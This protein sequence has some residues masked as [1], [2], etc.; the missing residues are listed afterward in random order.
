MQLRMTMDRVVWQRD[1]KPKSAVG[2][3]NQE[4]SQAVEDEHEG[5]VELGAGARSGKF[6]PGKDSPEGSD[7][8]C[9]LSDGVGNGHAG[10]ARGGH[11]EDGADAPDD[12]AQQTERM[13]GGGSV[14]KAAEVHGIADQRALHEVDVPDKAGEQGAERQEDAHTIGSEGVAAGHG[15]GDKRSPQAHQDAGN[16]ADYNTFSRHRTTGSGQ[17]AIGLAVKDY[18]QQ[19]AGHTGSQEGGASLRLQG[20][21]QHHAHDQGD[22]DGNRESDRQSGHVNGSDQ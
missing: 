14:E 16:D 11:I 13:A 4:N 3:G 5:E 12:S 2:A 6:L 8:G 19:R 18:R 10:Q 9:G 20:I 21:A 17:A 15:V 7:Y 22:A 1:P